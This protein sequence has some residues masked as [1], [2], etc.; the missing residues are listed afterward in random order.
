[1]Y[2]IICLYLF[3]FDFKMAQNDLSQNNN[4]IEAEPIKPLTPEKELT[5]EKDLENVPDFG[6]FEQGRERQ[7]SESHAE[8]PVKPEGKTGPE[9]NQGIVAATNNTQQQR[10]REKQIEQV[11]ESGL[12]D[13]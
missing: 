1:V 9:I 10:E 4:K 7:K 5:T 6:R 3:L 12:D 13:F 11:L 8:I 2:G